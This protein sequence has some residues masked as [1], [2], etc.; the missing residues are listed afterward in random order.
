M[1]LAVARPRDEAAPLPDDHYD[2]EL[3]PPCGDR[4]IRDDKPR[5]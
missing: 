3:E 4:A 1:M 2:H 5:V